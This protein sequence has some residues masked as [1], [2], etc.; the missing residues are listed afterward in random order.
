MNIRRVLRRPARHG[1]RPSRALV[2]A[3][4]LAVALMLLAAALPAAAAP[5]PPPPKLGDSPYGVN[6]H[7]PSGAHLRHLLDEAQAAGIGWVRI[8]FI[9]AVVQ[10]QRGT[11]DWSLYD[12]IVDEARSRGIEVLAILAY[13]PG[14]ATDGDAFNGVPRD[15]EDWRTFCRR[16]AERYRGRIAAWEIWNEPNLP[17][18]WAG[19]RAE[20]R[21]LILEPAALAIHA[22]DP[23][24]AAGGPGLAHLV[25][26]SRDWYAW[27]RETL[28]AKG[29]L[30]DFVSHHV[31]DSHGSRA[32]TDK[33]DDNTLFGDEPG[34]WDAVNPSLAEV[35]DYVG[36]SGPVWLTETG[37]ASNDVGEADQGAFLGGLLG[38]WFGDGASHHL[39]DKIF[40]YELQ[41]DPTPGAAKWGLLAADLREKAAYAVYR[42]FTAANPAGGEEP[43]ALELGDGRFAVEVVW[44]DPHNGNVGVGRPIPSTERTGFFWFFDPDNVELVV[45]V[46]DGRPVNGHH[47][48]FFG[49]LTD[50]EYWLTVTDR[51]RG[52]VATYYNPPL[53]LC[54]Q[55]DTAAFPRPAASAGG[56]E[57]AWTAS[58]WTAAS[59]AAPGPARVT[60]AT[61][62]PVS[63]ESAAAAAPC[64][65]ADTLCLQAHRFR[66][67]VAFYDQH[68]HRY[69][70][71]MAIPGTDDS[72]YF[73]FFD[74][75]NLELAVKVLDGRGVNGHW[76]VF[77][78]GLSDV[79]YDVTVTD[80]LDP[81]HPRHFHHAPG[82]ICG[83]ADTTAF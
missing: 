51:D 40:V 2:L 59:L 41:D 15:V 57:S 82:N 3:G 52:E 64:G 10:P 31:Y 24:A 13:T 36:W 16:A 32:V 78:G 68:N 47:W 77:F 34:L 25:S 26:G 75:A 35:L 12:E 73:W 48:V 1:F 38:R 54:G 72:G 55:G 71:G 19:S 11:F 28:E 83:Q 63:V 6:I 46:L 60:P 37:W 22:A 7:A 61:P 39:L 66:V 62:V 21:D 18:F 9:W 58:A 20:Y 74:P 17:Q 42:D 49:A 56:A 81:Q 8:D 30:L 23:A 67:E 80:A 69:G 53:Q 14:W 79:E 70:T 33:L 65:D 76:W 27:L 4:G 5:V 50:V 44:H 29:H 43:P 45:K